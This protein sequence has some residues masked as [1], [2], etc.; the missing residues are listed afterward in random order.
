MGQVKA[1]PCVLSSDMYLT[2]RLCVTYDLYAYDRY[3]PDVHLRYALDVYA[4]QEATIMSFFFFLFD[5]H[6][7]HYF[8]ATTQKPGHV[9][10]V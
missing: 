10:I 9:A 8:K 1:E 7:I 2:G 3:I 5:V 6:Y 4:F